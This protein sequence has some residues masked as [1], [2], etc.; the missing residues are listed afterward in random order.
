MLGALGAS[1]A[2]FLLAACGGDGAQADKTASASDSSTNAPAARETVKQF[3]ARFEDAAAAAASGDCKTVDSFNALSLVMLPCGG[4]PG[5]AYANLKVTGTAT[6]GTGGV[7]DF[8]DAEAPD[9]AT[10]LIG[11]DQSGKYGVMASLVSGKKEVGTK[12]RHL[13]VSDK[14]VKNFIRAVRTEDCD[15]YFEQAFT[16]SQ[17]KAKECKAEFAS[18]T[19]DEF[20]ADPG[21][22]PIRFGGVADF[23]FYGLSTKPDGYRTIVTLPGTSPSKV[24]VL[25][26]S[27]RPTT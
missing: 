18:S 10:L 23:V 2:L 6:F 15:A 20:A 24:V 5:K 14:G 8:T 9:G 21:A 17:N 7:V 1:I 16:F 27:A 12:P 25:S 26:Y 13:A 11:L 19:P 4:K 22:K 3:A